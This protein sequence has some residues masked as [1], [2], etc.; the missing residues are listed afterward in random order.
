ML[1]DIS[2]FTQRGSSLDLP[3]EAWLDSGKMR[4]MQ[5]IIEAAAA[6]GERVLIFSQ[7]VE[8]LH[9]ICQA[10]DV[11]R[12]SWLGFTGSTKVGDRQQLV[13]E[14]TDDPSIQCFLL[15][16]GA[17]GVGINLT[18]ANHVIL[19]DQNVSRRVS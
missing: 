19:Y 10:L 6:K 1:A 11:M 5:R 16:T 14:F 2:S 15:S 7:F 8:M 9:I 4:A 12:V 18:A 17:G 13:D 3:D